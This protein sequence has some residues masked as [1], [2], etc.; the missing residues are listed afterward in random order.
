MDTHTIVIGAGVVGLAV[1]RALAM[2]GR[3]V[4]VVERADR[5]GTETSSRNSEVIHSGIYYSPGSLKARLCVEGRDRLYTYCESRGIEHRRTGK[6]IVATS[7][8]EVPKLTRYRELAE[9]NKIGPVE[10]LSASDVHALEP[11]IRCVCALHVPQTGIVDSHALMVAIEGDLQALGGQVA[12]RSPFEG[13]APIEGG[14][15]VATGGSAATTLTCRE[16]VNCAG[17]SAPTVARKIK[18]LD[19]AKLPGQYFAKGHYFSLQGRSPFRRLIYPI[20]EAAGLGIHVTL[21]LAGQARFGP[22]VQWVNGPDYSFDD[23]R[24]TAFVAAIQRYFPAIDHVELT[25]AYTGVRPKI[26]PPNEPA[27]D[28]RIDGPADHGVPGLCNLMG[29]ESPGL[30]AALSIG[31]HIVETL[32][33][34]MS[35]HRR[36]Q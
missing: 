26:T 11:E 3:E 30:T 1:A 31:Q 23:T 15:E 4:L 24:K 29:I 36:L 5:I 12:L 32:R 8:A 7:D 25:A 13:A 19:P 10:W 2:S 16:L 28:F 6:L 17:L 21:D 20:P 35:A 14:F 27:A 34:P 18:G 9:M 33:I 22:D